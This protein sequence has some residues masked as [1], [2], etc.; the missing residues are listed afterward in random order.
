MRVIVR[1]CRLLE[2]ANNLGRFAML[3]DEHELFMR[4]DCTAVDRWELFDTSANMSTG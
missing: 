1:H 3:P 4:L 2:N